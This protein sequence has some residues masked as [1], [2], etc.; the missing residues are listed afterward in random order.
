M[1]KETQKEKEMIYLFRNNQQFNRWINHETKPTLTF[2]MKE[3]G[4]ATRMAWSLGMILYI[5]EDMDNPRDIKHVPN[6]IPKAA[7]S[8]NI[9]NIQLELDL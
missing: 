9:R 3:K 1:E 4:Y 5:P 7:C 2:K 8:V 6:G